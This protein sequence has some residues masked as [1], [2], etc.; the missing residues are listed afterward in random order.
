MRV[1]EPNSV[2]ESFVRSLN[3]GELTLCRRFVVAEIR[4]RRTIAKDGE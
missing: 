3:D 2:W 1:G 4:R